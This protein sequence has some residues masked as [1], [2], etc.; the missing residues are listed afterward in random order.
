MSDQS[1]RTPIAVVGMSCRLPGA[2]DLDGF[3]RL[4]K[5]AR[6]AVVEM[7][8]ER[9]D[10]DLYFDERKGQRGK[11]YSSIGG[12][13][14]AREPES[15]DE[16]FDMCHRLF[17]D[18]AVDACRHAGLG[19][20]ALAARSVGVFVG[21]SGGSPAF[22]GITLATL[23]EQAFEPLRQVPAVEAM[24]EE[25]ANGLIAGATARLRQ[26]RPQ[27]AANGDPKSESR[28]AAELVARA[29]GLTG[30]NLVI[31]AACSSSLVALALG[32]LALERGDVDVAV[33]GGASYAQS[34]S[35]ILFSQAQSCSARGSRPF[36]AAA[37]GL[38]GS[39]GYVA[40][41]L[42]TEAQARHDG[43]T[44][45]AVVRGIGLST[46]GRGRHLWAPRKEG[47]IAAMRRA[48]GTTI[49][50]GGIQY[51]EAHATSTQVGDATEIESMAEFFGDRFG[52][53]KIPIGS[54]KSNIGHTLETA[55]LA[56][57]LKVILSMREGA[58]PPTINI[59]TLNETIDWDAVPFEVT[60]SLRPWKRP[61]GDLRR[62]GVSAFGIGGL[63]VHLIVEEPGEAP[64]PVAQPA[65]PSR[66]PIAIVGRGMVVPGAG[67]VRALADFLKQGVPALSDAP[68]SR[69]PG[70]L[71][72][73]PDGA[74]WTTPTSRGGFIT[75]YAYDSVAHHVP[76]K[77][78]AAA[79]PLQFMLLDATEQA[80]AESGTV[81]RER[82]G[83]IVG[84][85]FGGE[86]GNQ[87]LLGLHFPEIRACLDQVMCEQGIGD[88][89]R[90]AIEDGYEERFFA[91]YPAVNDVTGS[92]TS[93]TLASRITKT[94]DLEGGAMAI[95]AGG[96]SSLVALQTA[97]ALLQA[98]A[99]SA[100]VC[101][102]AQRALDLPS[103]E[104]M[105]R[106]GRLTPPDDL[107]GEGVGAVILKRL[108][109]ARRDGNTIFG[110]VFEGGIRYGAGHAMADTERRQPSLS[111]LVGQLG[112][113][114]GVVSVI[115]ATVQ[116]AAE[117]EDYRA[118]SETGLECRVLLGPP[119]PARVAGGTEFRVSVGAPTR[120]GLRERLVYVGSG[121]DARFSNEDRFRLAIVS[122]DPADMPGRLALAESLLDSHDSRSLLEEQG[123]FMGEVG[124]ARPRVAFVFAGQGSQYAG[125]L[126][127]L[128]EHSPAAQ[129]AMAD[130]DRHLTA[131]GLGTFAELAWGDTARLD[132]DPVTT[133][134]AVL[135]A[136]TI[137]F[138][139]VTESGIEADCVCGHSFG[140]ISAMVAARVFTLEQAIRV[141]IARARA[142]AGANPDG[143]L[144]S[145]QASLEQVQD[146]I[147]A[148]RRTLYV[149]H[150]NSPTQTV[151]GGSQTHLAEFAGTLK[152]RGYKSTPL[153]VPG[154]L[155]SPLAKPA[156]A[157][158][159]A[160]LERETLLP[161]T[162]LFYSNV[163]RDQVVRAE[164]FVD[165][166]VAQ[167]AE[168]L[169]YPSLIQR[170]VA[171]GVGALV[172]I[173]PS[174]VL[175]RLH[176]QIVGWE[177]V[178]TGTDHPRRS[179]WE[180]LERA[181]AA[182]E[183][184][185]AVDARSGAP[186]GMHAAPGRIV[187]FDATT[188]RREKRRAAAAG[189]GPERV[190]NPDALPTAANVAPPADT[191]LANL[192]LDFVV[193]LTGYPRDA[194]S[195]D[196]DLEADLG[197]DS[198]KRTQLVGEMAEA[199]A[200]ESVADD[201]ATLATL[202]T[203]RELLGYFQAASTPG[204]SVLPA[205]APDA[206]RPEQLA[207]DTGLEQGR[208][209]AS[210][211]RALLR[212]EALSISGAWRVRAAE[213]WRA[214]LSPRELSELQG[215]AD[216]AGVHVGNVVAYR[217]RH[218][219]APTQGAADIVATNGSHPMIAPPASRRYVM[220]MVDLPL[221]EN[222]RGRPL[223]GAALV[224]GHNPVAARLCARLE[225][226]GVTVHALVPDGPVKN[227]VDELNRLW[228]QGP[229]THL[230]FATSRDAD[231]ASEL[232][233][234]RWGRRRDRALMTP[235]S[236]CQRWM[237]L[238]KRD[239]L[240]DEASLVGLTELG[241][242]FG[243]S[244]H[245]RSFE[246]G[247]LTGLF[248]AIAIESWVAGFRHLPVKLIDASSEESPETIVNAAL[249]ELE[250]PSYEAEVGVAHGA[251]RV[252][253][254]VRVDLPAAKGPVHL[255]RTWVC[256]GGA[257]GIT[258]YVAR[259]LGRRFGLSL[260]LIGRAA[261]MNLPA[262]WRAMWTDRRRELK[263]RVMDAARTA[264]DNPV[265]AWES[266]QKSLEI[267]ETLAT[268]QK[269]GVKATY[270]SCDISDRE[271]LARVLDDVRA[272]GPIDGI[273]HGAGSSRD[274]KFE[275][276]EPHRVDQ[277]FRAK[278][279]GTLALMD[280]TRDDPLRYFVAFGSVSGRFGANGHAD[281]S[282]ANDMM[283]KVVDWYRGQ[284]P[285]VAAVT[286]HWHAWGDVGMATKAE[287]QL[288][289]QMVDMEFMPAAEGLEHMVRE[290]HA[291]AP[292]A[293]VL[294]TQERYFARFYSEQTSA[295]ELSGVVRP[296][297]GSD[298]PEERGD[299][300]VFSCALDPEKDVFLR[301]HQ[302][303][304][305][306]LLPLVAGLE[307][308]AEAALDNA[309]GPFVVGPVE[310]R[311]GLRF[312]DAQPQT[313]R[314]RVTRSATGAASCDVV[315]DFRARDGTLLEGDRPI[316]RAT[317][318]EPEGA[319]RYTGALDA[320]APSSEWQKLA[321]DDSG[322]RFYHG[323]AFQCLRRFHLT[324]RGLRGAIVAPAIVEM[325]GTGRPAVG[326]RLHLAV[327]DACFY[328]TACLAWALDPG[329][330]I[331]AG[332]DELFIGRF[333]MPRE[334]CVVQVVAGEQTDEMGR[335]DFRLYGADGQTLMDAKGYRIAR[336]AAKELVLR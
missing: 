243:F 185:G 169:D 300:S 215:M 118:A 222:V 250:I 207:Y 270:H 42:K 15:G 141:T 149:T 176:R 26:G 308:A 334:D 220:G 172:E 322:L 197:L 305:R 35:L 59:E 73:S 177:V 311:N 310:I 11:T 160:A 119:P 58:I 192:L 319:P 221:P 321:Y 30:P 52:G 234:G 145:V 267:E 318:V 20:E 273:L 93:S 44:I 164:D 232:D 190:V 264:G 217:L 74:P 198:I 254:P 12:L 131:A 336:I 135:V 253:R 146:L 229:V 279:D 245:V 7:P 65:S 242:D 266:A 155:H 293:E 208:G 181:R 165:N 66:E 291:G 86:F 204:N 67:N 25:R 70:R 289:L 134:I 260:H 28:W 173:G 129:R 142:L 34:S 180:Q 252:V 235:F 107:P 183:C 104:T 43:D 3:W 238:L 122:A 97:C 240:M 106:R 2:N 82:T 290:L 174:Q 256:T 124:P 147:A 54:V 258:A 68:E 315:S 187:E 284:R 111:S 303:D 171:D 206:R 282:T 105:A 95:D 320:S 101:A 108:S 22:G 23:A 237:A 36:D 271:A 148:Q 78:V 116:P 251:R 151:V 296:L 189:A 152:A 199:L 246:S 268:L 317:F 209:H 297:L 159:R 223:R 72:V 294:I 179:A 137:M 278:L 157:P 110:I 333:P 202:S 49:D 261:R 144:L 257:R 210:V 51:V 295:A 203:L 136:D 18:V 79:N 84:T 276:K 304:G 19:R 324:E 262:E 121:V 81:D 328:A 94:F 8:P 69:W 45:Y 219:V 230:F 326:W 265:K 313:V 71:G 83:V 274:A 331:P 61:Q 46:D 248:K 17:A 225:Q 132:E 9:L 275:Q 244:G 63:N 307:L 114:Q 301:E 60:R 263:V 126:K 280:A 47:Q 281:Y 228:E 156:Q 5:E 150:H 167:L 91:R 168:P 13:V 236:L 64:L 241:G 196:W 182:L 100:I 53:A 98:N 335:F 48:Y 85:S 200:L 31:D 4:L 102:G 10:R 21:H 239:G 272:D 216:G 292:E 123:I 1:F 298:P 138:A 277:C 38:V 212:G 56:S 259:E 213:E 112:A 37:D 127:D 286:F 55:G 231:A 226:E 161:P 194:I 143:G 24:G 162:R 312:V 113:A 269:V 57:L 224:V 330:S 227:A 158:L 205:T 306:P 92:F 186:S 332:I 80:L 33:V 285:D 154:A 87:L 314:V 6:S 125:M 75:D 90:R 153:R 302:L 323:P 163:T 309:S 27:R 249:R 218:G 117:L 14:E 41:V 32:A 29:L 76:P 214:E 140:E 201:A 130:A 329:H 327:L 184:V 255:G 50:P 288:G 195:L 96:A 99:C 247:A 316:I 115:R 109:D 88:R 188:T 233:A 325:G 299:I 191:A 139:A 211:I 283:A 16:T 193:D 178:C 103:F 89:E 120:A 133:Q 39:E 62:A 287:T 175:T 128:V 170:L 77:Q 166:L 40:V